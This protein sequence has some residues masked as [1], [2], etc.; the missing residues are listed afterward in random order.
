[1]CRDDDGFQTIDLIKLVGFSIRRTGHAGQL[2][3]HPEVVLERDGSQR[4]ILFLDGDTFLRLD[5]LMQAIGPATTS[6]H[7]A[8]KLIDDDDLAVTHDIMLVAMIKRLR[9]QGSIEMMH[10]TDIAGVIQT[11]TLSQQTRFSQHRFCMLMPLLGHHDLMRFFIHPVIALT[12]LR[13]LAHQL[14]G[15]AVDLRV[16][17]DAIVRLTGNNQRRTGLVNQNRVNLINQR[18]T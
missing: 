14:G 12:I 16:K 13:L 3:I 15:K 1:V 6:H 9:A 2:F 5:R 8:G 18:I 4:L 10:Q 11:G 7:A 17:F